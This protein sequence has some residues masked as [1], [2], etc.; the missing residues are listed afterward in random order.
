M[1]IPFETLPADAKVW[2]YPAQETLTPHQESIVM[3][4]THNFIDQWTTHGEP[5]SA[6]FKVLEHRFL[7]IAAIENA[8][9]PSGCSIDSQVHFVQ[10]LENT[11]HISL[12]ERGSIPVEKEDGEI[13]SMSLEE[14]RKEISEGILAPNRFFYDIS[15]QSINGL[16]EQFKLKIEQ[17]WPKRFLAKSASV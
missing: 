2:I 3:E 12:T 11:L 9:G 13:T 8:A 16:R 1:F 6:S 10:K 4:H 15:I 5:V 7:V 17:G 14:F